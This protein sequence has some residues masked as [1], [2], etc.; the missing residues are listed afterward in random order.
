MVSQCCAACYQLV[1]RKGFAL[2]ADV[3]ERGKA[4]RVMC[5]GTQH[6]QFRCC[7]GELGIPKNPEE[8]AKLRNFGAG[9]S[10][11]AP[12]SCSK[13]LSDRHDMN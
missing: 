8:A 12:H 13:I 1:A 9:A 3:F 6:G 5:S 2:L 7:Q 10:P 11:H 4:V